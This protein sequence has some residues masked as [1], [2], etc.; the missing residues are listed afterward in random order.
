MNLIKKISKM[1]WLLW[2][3]LLIFIVSFIATITITVLNL[4]LW[5]HSRSNLITSLVGLCFFSMAI[6]ILA[7]SDSGKVTQSRLKLMLVSSLLVTTQFPIS[8]TGF[9][10]VNSVFIPL[11]VIAIGIAFWAII[12]FVIEDTPQEIQQDD[13]KEYCSP[14]GVT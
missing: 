1:D 5:K 13:E 6:L 12:E 9:R 8:L 10:H 11:T 3:I 7:G 2:L 4:T 14:K